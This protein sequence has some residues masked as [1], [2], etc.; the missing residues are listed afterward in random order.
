MS[1]GTST[2]IDNAG[3]EVFR[4]AGSSGVRARPF[5]VPQNRHSVAL[6]F[7]ALLVSVGCDKQKGTPINDPAP[8]P[9]TSAPAAAAVAQDGPT[10]TLDLG[11]NLKLELVRVPA[12]SFMMGSPA[13]EDGHDDSESPVH[14]VTFAKPFYI[15][16]FEVTQS[17]FVK[18]T[19]AKTFSLPGADRPCEEIN[20]AEAKWFCDNTAKLTGRVVRL[21]S[22]AEW[23]YAA[24][25]GTTTPFWFGKEATPKQAN[26]GQLVGGPA[27]GSKL[28]TTK[29]GSYPPNPWGLYDTV[30]NVGEWCQDNMHDDYKGAPADGSAWETPGVTSRVYRGGA[31]SN[32]PEACRA[33]YRGAS[34]EPSE[35]RNNQKGFRVVL[36][37]K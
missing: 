7:L 8:P 9:V 12:G 18:M 37:S 19:G 4:R 15:G 27:E 33:A 20:W 26:L 36:E 22:E 23:E 29:V 2:T 21:P 16:K 14:K 30:G 3:S 24:R 17:Q 35:D 34:S 6:L 11:G 13:D 31:Y 25:A 10:L 28:D 5:G 32:M 1:K